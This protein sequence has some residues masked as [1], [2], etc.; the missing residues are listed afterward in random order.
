MALVLLAAAGCSREK[1]TNAGNSGSEPVTARATVE[2]RQ[3]L[4]DASG[5]FT[6]GGKPIHPALVY[7]FIPWLSDSG[8]VAVAV[9]LIPAQKSNKYFQC[10][11]QLS[12]QW[13]ECDVR[14]LS[15]DREQEQKFGYRRLGVLTDGTHVI[16]TY[17]WGGGSGVFYDLVL[18]RFEPEKTLDSH[19][20]LRMRIVMKA[21]CVVP[22]GDRDDGE[23][24]VLPDRV[25]VGRSK[26]R[27]KEVVLKLE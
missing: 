15:P 27:E 4:Q 2:L 12:E 16:K 17:Y 25:I 1:Q 9:D 10:L 13:I 26:Y 8:P 14:S 22:L 11:V 23:V 18:V 7:E 19:G 5:P 21:L 6:C 20:T 3:A 24:R